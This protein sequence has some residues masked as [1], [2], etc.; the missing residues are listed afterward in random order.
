MTFAEIAS[1]FERVGMALRSPSMAFAH[2]AY[3]TH[4]FAF[5]LFWLRNRGYQVRAWEDCA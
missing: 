3:I 2:A 5:G 4:K 1:C